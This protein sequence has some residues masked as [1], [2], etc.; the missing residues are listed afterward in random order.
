MPQGFFCM[1]DGSKAIRLFNR[2]QDEATVTAK[3]AGLGRS[4][5]ASC[6]LSNRPAPALQATPGGSSQVKQPARTAT[7]RTP[8][9]APPRPE[10][11]SRCSFR[12]RPI[13][14][15]PI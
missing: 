15:H 10:G 11:M 2:G 9:W 6:E 5:N 3:W 1:E 8:P 7:A 14:L 4:G 13:C 12:C